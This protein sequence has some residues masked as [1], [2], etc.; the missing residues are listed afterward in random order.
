MPESR[1]QGDR[2]SYISAQQ[3]RISEAQAQVNLISKPQ[4][5][6]SLPSYDPAY[7]QYQLATNRPA[8]ERT[9][10]AS[11]VNPYNVGTVQGLAQ[12]NLIASSLGYTGGA[13]NLFT[14]GGV[15][16]IVPKDVATGM[17]Y[18]S[19]KAM[20]VSPQV[21]ALQGIEPGYGNLVY[22]EMKG[23]GS[24]SYGS[25]AAEIAASGGGTTATPHGG[26]M[27]IGSSAPSTA[28]PGSP[29]D[30]V[31]NL[32]LEMVGGIIQGLGGPRVGGTSENKYVANEQTF[33]DL[34]IPVGTSWTVSPGMAGS[35][36]QAGVT[37][38]V[39]PTIFT[40][41]KIDT[42]IPIGSSY[43]YTGKASAVASPEGGAIFYRTNNYSN[44]LNL[45]AVT[46]L[47]FGVFAPFTTIGNPAT[48]GTPLWYKEEIALR[49]ETAIRNDPNRIMAAAQSGSYFLR[50][51]MGEKKVSGDLVYGA[52][53]EYSIF[54][55]TYDPNTGLPRS[56]EVAI[57]GGGRNALQGGGL[58]LTSFYPTTSARYAEIVKNNPSLFSRPGA[59]MYG[60]MVLPLRMRTYQAPSTDINSPYFSGGTSTQMGRYPSW[61]GNLGNLV[62]S[63]AVNVGRPSLPTLDIPGVMP[64]WVFNAGEVWQMSRGKTDNLPLF[65]QVAG[66]VGVPKVIAAAGTTLT[67][68][69]PQKL[70]PAID[71]SF[72]SGRNITQAGTPLPSVIPG[73]FEGSERLL[74]TQYKGGGLSLDN[75]NAWVGSMIGIPR[76]A[77][78]D[79]ATGATAAHEA[80]KTQIQQEIAA[81]N[82]FLVGKLNTKGQLVGTQAE[83]DQYYKMYNKL[84]IDKGVYD[85]YEKQATG[86]AQITYN[87]PEVTQPQGTDFWGGVANAATNAFLIGIFP[88][89]GVLSLFGG[90]KETTSLP[91]PKPSALAENVQSVY[92]VGGGVLIPG[93]KNE[94][95]KYEYRSDPLAVILEGSVW[96]GDTLSFGVWKPGSALLTKYG[97]NVN[98]S[99][100]T[101]NKNMA[102]VQAGKPANDAL[103]TQI[104]QEISGMN[105]FTAGKINANNQFTGTPAE[106]TQYQSMY[107][108]LDIDMGAFN[109]YGKKYNDVITS[110]FSS[111]AIISTSTGGYTAN[112]NNV[113]EYGAFSDWTAGVGKSI[114]GMFGLNATPAQF[115]A[116]E[117]T[118]E[119]K[120]LNPV[121]QVGEVGWK[122]FALHP[123][124]IP[125]T[126]LQI[127]ELYAM[128]GT[129]SDI[130]EGLAPAAGVA[131]VGTVQTLASW[132]LKAA[133]IANYVVPT[134]FVGV[135]AYQATSGF[136]DFG[137]TGV[138]N[139][140]EMSVK[141]V[142]GADLAMGF[143]SIPGSADSA[144]GMVNDISQKVSDFSYSFQQGRLGIENIGVKSGSDFFDVNSFGAQN[145]TPQSSISGYL[146]KRTGG[147]G[148]FIDIETRSNIA[149]AYTA[150]GQGSKYPL[151][152]DVGAFID[153]TPK[154]W[155]KGA[156]V[157][158]GL[159][160]EASDNVRYASLENLYGYDQPLLQTSRQVITPKNWFN[161]ALTTTTADVYPSGMRIAQT[162]PVGRTSTLT[163]DKAKMGTSGGIEAWTTEPR[164]TMAVRNRIDTLINP[165]SGDTLVMGTKTTTTTPSTLP[166]AIEIG[167][168]HFNIYDLGL[169]IATPEASPIKTPP[170]DAITAANFRTKFLEAGGYRDT[171]SI[172]TLYQR[173]TAGGETFGF[174]Q[175]TTEVS[176]A[177]NDF[178]ESKTP[179]SMGYYGFNDYAMPNANRIKSLSKSTPGIPT[180]PLKSSGGI[181]EP[182]NL[183]GITPKEFVPTTSGKVAGQVLTPADPFEEYQAIMR[184]MFGEL[185][186]RQKPAPMKGAQAAYDQVALQRTRE[187]NTRM[188]AGDLLPE[189]EALGLVSVYS[190]Q[191]E[192]STPVLP[193]SVFGPDAVGAIARLNTVGG[194]LRPY[195]SGLGKASRPAS[196][197]YGGS[198]VAYGGP[199]PLTITPPAFIKGSVSPQIISPEKSQDTF[200][201]LG[202]GQTPQTGSEEINIFSPMVGT[203]MASAMASAQDQAQA[204]YTPTLQEQLQEIQQQPPENPPTK[205]TFLFPPFPIKIES[206]P[207][208]SGSGGRRPGRRHTELFLTGPS[209]LSSLWNMFGGYGG[210]A[211]RQ[212]KRYVEV[213]RQYQ[214]VVGGQRTRVLHEYKTGGGSRPTPRPRQPA[215]RAPRFPD[216]NTRIMPG[217]RQPAR[218]RRKKGRGQWEELW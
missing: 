84:D 206:G 69:A 98:P 164:G 48:Y 161:Q 18:G 94:P 183:K 146:P 150:D 97:Q 199:V 71:Y 28:S 77:G 102:D 91:T 51:G 52:T 75:L 1:F 87:P 65:T 115:A 5:G 57:A 169:S 33:R 10:A 124:V 88:P 46:A 106:F 111:G 195:D 186:P 173:F 56:Y 50:E 179:E 114:Q 215:M 132:A 142:F 25:I 11:G 170:V 96:A 203:A 171:N 16:G 133:P 72:S 149:K 168:A 175:K 209:D 27:Y 125:A 130:L 54:Q 34:G 44:T 40:P 103:Q 58:S 21:S 13:L 184:D 14:L 17:D 23:L 127:V 145:P 49:E 144:V 118:P 100:E 216:M 99:L 85:A 112:P 177:F 73:L 7:W 198:L 208:G 140:G 141:L 159:P 4:A 185:A 147:M 131:P 201:F 157:G 42:G 128:Q 63:N 29:A 30:I 217:G 163:F 174:S 210:K 207:G 182:I 61:T 62:D 74:G 194:D 205:N 95:V 139:L 105:A 43:W 200:S 104:V 22:P 6:A 76:A 189:S 107:K 187:I 24:G 158:S 172:G 165:Y 166:P 119:F 137:P 55:K 180:N 45:G 120:N 60:G 191:S 214:S 64:T 93:A 167:K 121:L 81:N 83:I 109:D 3:S 53:G 176:K 154:G 156:S 36:G 136:R 138:S 2:Q 190:P 108:K 211:P 67:T 41:A 123:E 79:Q 86:G 37:E 70:N 20:R 193:T 181:T 26:S 15:S 110:G 39:R 113:K 202:F 47:T 117:Q 78:A 204:L 135:G 213:G 126:A 143:L 116:Y 218:G 122:V 68:S 8:A 153:S 82:A 196:Q 212:K 32:R 38:G 89:L 197:I 80:L 35:W 178:L 31:A 90:N 9:L 19:F 101:F 192:P 151:G 66:G 134:A 148:D 152:G 162:T 129:G 160:I 59:E 188:F 92:G 155:F 12:E